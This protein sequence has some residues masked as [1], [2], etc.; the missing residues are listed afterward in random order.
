[1]LQKAKVWPTNIEKDGGKKHSFSFTKLFK[2]A[3]GLPL[4]DKF[5]KHST[6]RNVRYI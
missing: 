4:D 3:I 2:I 5:K 1:M 6:T